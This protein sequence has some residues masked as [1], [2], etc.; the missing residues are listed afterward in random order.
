MKKSSMLFALVFLGA[1]I[2]LAQDNISP[3]DSVVNMPKMYAGI[4]VG[5]FG[6]GI[7]FAYTFTQMITL[8]A[9]G[10]YFP[11]LKKTNTGT[12]DGAVTTTDYRFQSGGAGIMGD[13]SFFKTKP[14]IRFSTG[15]LYNS[16]RATATR[17]YYLKDDEM[18]L[19]TLAME[20]TPKFKISPYLG[21][22]IGNLKNSKHFFFTL[23][24]GMLYQGKPQLVFTGEG[25][26]SPTANES[27]TAI[28]EDNVKSLQVY[29]YMNLQLNYKF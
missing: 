24:M 17:T 3:T 2:T 14:G 27:N 18:D 9:T 13:F 10:S 22:L 15:V 4:H 1:K 5:S 21:M 23:E 26:I 29:P 25:H 11:P 8:R 19:G 6:G 28:I 7:Q 12:E 20:F 16:S